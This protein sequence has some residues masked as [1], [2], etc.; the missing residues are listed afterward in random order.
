MAFHD[1]S[2]KVSKVVAFYATE[3]VH[4]NATN[5]I[6]EGYEFRGHRFVTIIVKFFLEEIGYELYFNIEYIIS[7]IDRKF[8]LKVFLEIIDKIKKISSS[9]TIRGINTNTHDISEYIRL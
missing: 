7:L 4:F 8:L 9:I 2:K 1:S 5:V 3:V 6:I